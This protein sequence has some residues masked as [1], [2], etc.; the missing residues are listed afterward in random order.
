[1][2]QDL[3]Q[4]QRYIDRH[5]K[6]GKELQGYIEYGS[7]CAEYDR[8]FGELLPEGFIRYLHERAL[9]GKPRNVLDIMASAGFLRSLADKG[10]LD[11]GAVANVTNLAVQAESLPQI[12]VHYRNDSPQGVPIL[13]IDKHRGA[14]EQLPPL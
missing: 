7:Q 6:G 14:P 4:R 1:M 5:K 9:R 13:H 10:V 11:R 8:A 3:L 12:S 2:R